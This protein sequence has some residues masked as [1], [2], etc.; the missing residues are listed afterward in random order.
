MRNGI[1][2]IAPRQQPLHVLAQ[3]TGLRQ[4]Q[5]RQGAGRRFIRALGRHPQQGLAAQQ[6]PLGPC[7]RH[8][9]L[10]DDHGDA[11]VDFAA[12]I[13]CLDRAALH[14]RDVQAHLRILLVQAPEHARHI[15]GP[16]VVR[17]A[18]PQLASQRNATQIPIGLVAQGQ[19]GPGVRQ[20][21]FA[22]R[23]G[24]HAGF[25]SQQQRLAGAVLQ[26]AHLL[27]D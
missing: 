19:D 24:R 3:R 20:Q 6:C 7:A 16:E 14:D 23:S 12:L 8:A 10:L 15:A 27:A 2:Q 17:D 4:H 5:Q 22:G 26:L 1:R 21:A 9:P 11:D 18:Q 25:A 13:G